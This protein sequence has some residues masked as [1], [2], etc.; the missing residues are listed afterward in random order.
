MLFRS[1]VHIAFG[2]PIEIKGN[3]AEENQQVI[4]FIKQ[5]LTEWG[6]SDLIVE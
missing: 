6:R 2:K 1:E 5:K 3:G 4:D